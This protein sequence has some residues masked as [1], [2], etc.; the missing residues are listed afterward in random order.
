MLL[1]DFSCK[2][3]CITFLD[4]GVSLW[5]FWWTEATCCVNESMLIASKDDP[6][7]K[8]RFV[9]ICI[10]KNLLPSVGFLCHVKVVIVNVSWVFVTM[11][12]SDW[13]RCWWGNFLREPCPTV[14]EMFYNHK[15]L[16]HLNYFGFIKVTLWP[17]GM[18]IIN[19]RND[20]HIWMIRLLKMWPSLIF[21]FLLP[22]PQPGLGW[23]K[24]TSRRQGCKCRIYQIL[25]KYQ[26]YCI[27]QKG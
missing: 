13:L 3:I 20:S 21:F 24:C 5:D 16:K 27:H 25:P 26:A 7:V 11:P 17:G 6:C 12:F 1:F 18:S 10:F 8:L 14:W 19:A 23:L 9:Y 2:Y 15:Y 22:K 4:S